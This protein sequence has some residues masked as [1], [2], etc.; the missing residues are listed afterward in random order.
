M[1]YVLLT[2]KKYLKPMK[3]PLFHH[4]DT[5]TYYNDHICLL[6]DSA[7]ASTPSQAAG[8]GQGL[9]DALLLSRIL[10][11]VKSA[12]QSEKAFQVYDA[13]RR[14]RAQGVVRESYNVAIEYFLEHPEFGSDLQKITDAANQRLPQIWW[15]DLEADV[16]R[17]AECFE[18]LTRVPSVEKIETS[19]KSLING[20]SAETVTKANGTT[21]SLT[22]NGVENGA[23]TNGNSSKGIHNSFQIPTTWIKHCEPQLVLS[24]IC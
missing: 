1:I 14:P 16:R 21:D 23:L 12:D 20:N 4:P 6:G 15:H 10:G 3:W 2:A 8:A 13:I 7:H 5:P 9:E 24:K 22:S 11:L 18:L 19:S 17:A